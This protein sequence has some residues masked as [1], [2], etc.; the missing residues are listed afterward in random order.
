MDAKSKAAKTLLLKLVEASSE[1]EVQKIIEDDHYLSKEQNWKPYGGYYGNFNIIHNQQQESVASLVEKPI[2]A[3]DHLLLKECKLRGINP[4]GNKAPKSM[5]EAI[6]LFFGIK[7]GDF[8][9]VGGTKR[10]ELASNILIIAE[11]SR[12]RPNIAVADTG[13]GQHPSHFE[14]TFVSLSRGNKDKIRFVQGK[15]NM[16]GTGVLA[17]CGEHHYQLFLS[18]KTPALLES[19]QDDRWGFTLVRLHEV[20][21][22]D[23]YKNSWYEYCVDGNVE[24]L[25][26]PGETLNILPNNGGFT[27]GTYVKMFNY[28]LHD[29]SIIGLGL[30]RELNRFLYAP[31]LPLMLYEARDYKGHSR[32]KLMLGNKMRTTVD[33]RDSVE[34]TLTIT[35][36]LG[37]FGKRNIEV[38]LFKEGTSKSEFTTQDDAIFFTIN[39]QTHATLGRSFLR[40]KAKL[41]YLADYL[42]VHIDC[43]D[44]ET[45]IREQIFMPSRERMR[46]DPISKEVEEI[47][48]DELKRHEGLQQLNQFRREQ[49]IIKNP[50]DTEFLEGVVSNLI[51]NNRSLLNFLGLGGGVKDVNEPG[52]IEIEKYEGKRFPTY[53]EILSYS[54]KDKLYRKQIPV[55]SYAR[56]KLKTDA[57]NDY[58]D[59]AS[60]N[61]E[62]KMTP[63]I[64]S[65]FHLWN[66][67]ITV[68][69]VPPHSAKAGEIQKCKI[70]LTR[71]YDDSLF[72]EFEVE[73]TP[74][75]ETRIVKPGEKEPDKGQAYKL[76]EPFFVY[77]E[78]ANGRMSWAQMSWAQEGGWTG[79]DIAKVAPSGSTNGD[80]QNLDVYINMDADI[81][82]DY[83]RRQQVSQKQQELIERSWETSIFLN[84][85][86]LYN[87]LS[88]LEK[89]EM[90]PDIMKSISKITLD[91][92]RNELLLKELETY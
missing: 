37:K 16:G 21:S 75:I 41:Y 67:I 91:L 40:T 10:R 54:P 90:L 52:P 82:H 26:F 55:N 50:K 49:Q 64:I 92:M 48:A 8:S 24:I 11:G 6:E 34:H 32:T 9:E 27:S 35:A 13:E 62:L 57:T 74:P 84:S 78:D 85:L 89:E 7:K 88:K 22:S 83:L 79:E 56:L 18:R 47:L 86:V 1:G 12:E 71:P 30:W 68:K 63:D 36:E 81:L 51:K 38:T 60:E 72:V 65:S 28:Y 76:P 46:H 5:Q 4:E 44:V 19:N 87:D 14:D 29:P 53:L 39:G 80:E 43:T 59:R 25:S 23:P 3:I 77:K 42:L 33:D 45:N 61:G 70:E 69:L 2:N 73:Y 20:S 58:F 15:Y 66:G 31:A 17:F